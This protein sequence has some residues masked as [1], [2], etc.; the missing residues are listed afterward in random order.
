MITTYSLCLENISVTEYDNY[1]FFSLC[2]FNGEIL[3]AN[4]GGIFL[5]SGDDNDDDGAEI[6]SKVVFGLD[7]F[8]FDTL[9]RITGM[10]FLGDF[11][12]DSIQGILVVNG[13][14]TIRELVRSRDHNE[15]FRCKFPKGLKWRK[16]QVGFQNVDGKI[17][18]LQNLEL[19]ISPLSRRIG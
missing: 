19:L 12:R 11:P 6:E 15:A 10:Y 3:G 16:S 14:E 7:D 2:E 9:K 5:L 13:T 1:N 18:E 4:S 8:S 17:F